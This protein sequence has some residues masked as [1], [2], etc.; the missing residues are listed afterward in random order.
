MFLLD[1]GMPPLLEFSRRKV[2][3]AGAEAVAAR[4]FFRVSQANCVAP[5]I[6]CIR[7]P[8]NTGK[9]INQVQNFGVR[10]KKIRKG[11]YTSLFYFILFIYM[12][13]NK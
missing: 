3:P 2:A 1:F 13:R 4:V 11:G 12:M 5:V 9:Y 10:G 7:L 8:Q 6:V